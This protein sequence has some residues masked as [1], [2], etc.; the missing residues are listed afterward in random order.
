MIDLLT[1]LKWIE[2]HRIPRG[3]ALRMEAEGQTVVASSFVDFLWVEDEFQG[4]AGI[5]VSRD[6]VLVTDV[7]GRLVRYLGRNRLSKPLAEVHVSTERSRLGFRRVV[8]ILSDQGRME[9]VFAPLWYRD[10]HQVCR[11]IG[12]SMGG[13]E[14]KQL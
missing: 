2:F 13:M 7:V 1:P 9:L 10:M 5:A 6:R 11:S 8:R 12:D 3:L 14:S 4:S